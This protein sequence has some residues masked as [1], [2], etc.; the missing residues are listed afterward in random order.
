MNCFLRYNEMHQDLAELITMLIK[1][2]VEHHMV[3]LLKKK[4]SCLS[5]QLHE[6]FERMPS[7]FYFSLNFTVLSLG[8]RWEF[9]RLFLYYDLSPFKSFFEECKLT[10]RK[11]FLEFSGNF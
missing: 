5:F 6:E 10:L 3:E 7:R 9:L 11:F 8:M 4:I 1:V 2:F